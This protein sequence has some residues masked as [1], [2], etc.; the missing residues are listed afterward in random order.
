MPVETA[1]DEHRVLLRYRN[2]A[3]TP[4]DIEF[5]RELCAAQ[6][7]KR[8]EL[9]LAVCEAWGWRQANGSPA[10]YACSDLL[11]RL[12]ER[13]LL[14]LP[15]ARPRSRRRRW[16][17]SL[18]IPVDLIPLCGL[19]VRDPGADLGQVCV[20]PIQPEERLGWRVYMERYHPL[21]H[22]P[23]VG[24]HL[25]YAAFVADELVAL[26]GWAAAA[27]R[28][29]VRDAWVGWDEATKRR[30]L[31]LVTNNIRFL[32]LPWVRVRHLASKVLAMNLRRLAADWTQAWNHPVLL[33]ETFVD[34]GRHRGAC[35]RA[36]NW[37]YLGQ[38]AGRSKRGNQYL[39]GATKKLMF[40]YPLHRHVRR[41]LVDPPSSNDAPQGI[42][43][44]R[45]ST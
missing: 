42:P 39:R 2:R 41:L 44:C 34:T 10:I 1:A 12:E 24:E 38:T 43:G 3:I 4:G 6:W 16:L 26:L 40:V 5:L 14:E 18:P 11:L 22:R 9:L 35:Y 45:A 15:L 27:F 31:H 36:A 13:G 21:G 25:L 32:I 17:T 30:R 23:I 28:A 19:E 37:L 33:A 8:R 7:S 20:R 29:P